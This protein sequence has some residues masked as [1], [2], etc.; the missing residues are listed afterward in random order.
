MTKL[1]GAYTLLEQAIAI[2]LL[3]FV[4]MMTILILD[5]QYDSDFYD[6]TKSKVAIIEKAIVAH[7]IRYTKDASLLSGNPFLC[8]A[9]IAAPITSSNFGKSNSVYTDIGGDCSGGYAVDSVS[10]D[11][12]YYGAIPVR[13]LGLSDDYAFDEWGRRLLFLVHKDI[14][15][16]YNTD[17]EVDDYTQI[18]YYIISYGKNGYGAY[19][20]AG[21]LLSDINASSYEENNII[22]TID[23]ANIQDM[24]RQSDY[25]DVVVSKTLMQFMADLSGGTLYTSSECSSLQ[26]PS[27]GCSESSDVDKV[28][29]YSCV[30]R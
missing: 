25:D 7:M 23:I 15:Q 14:F 17:V 30:F 12:Y 27:G 2:T 4:V 29:D 8:P 10:L 20:K 19:N 16:T 9:L 3:S 11:N 21:E 24:P 6:K 18:L 1:R 28:I 26:P 5:Y 22:S 13:S